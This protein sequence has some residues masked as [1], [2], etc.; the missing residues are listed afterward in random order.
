VKLSLR[1]AARIAWRET[2][3]SMT[4]FAFVVVAVALGVGALA[5][6]RGFS[7]SVR[8]MLASQTR[9]ILAADLTARQFT[10]PNAE[11]ARKL[12]ALAA[13]GIDRTVI[14]ET[15]SMASSEAPDAVPVLVSLKA[16]DPAKYPYY[17][18]VKLAP[19]MPLAEALRPDT[20][21]AGEDVLIRLGVQVGDWVKLGNQQ[22]RVVA[23]VLSEPDRMSGSL[24][25][26]L[27]VML[28]RAA[29]ERTGLMQFGSRA[30]QRFLFKLGPGSPDVAQAR[31]LLREALP[32]ALVADSTEAHPLIRRGVDRATVFLSLVSLIALIVGA[33]GVAMAMYAHLQQKLDNIAVM[34]SL[35]ATSREIIRIFTLQTLML[36][37]LG[38][39]GGV[40]VGRVI[41]EVF[42]ALVSQIFEIQAPTGWHL[43][44]ALQ[45]VAVGT[46]TTLL[47]TLPPLLAIR[48]V[49]PALILR[50]GMPEA[51]LPLRQRLAES[52]DALAAGLVLLAG[53]AGIAAWLAGSVR[54]GGYFAL[55]LTASLAAL[56]AVAWGLLRLLRGWLRRPPVRLG[57]VTR[58]GLAN[59]HRQGS[60]AQAILVAMSLGVMFTLSVYLIQNSLIDDIVSSAPPGVPNVFLMGATPE[61]VE[62]LK[63]LLARQPGVEGP[64]ELGPSISAQLVKINGRTDWAVE[65]TPAQR[66]A[67]PRTV[68][69][70]DTLP[71]SF[72]ILEGVW[73]RPGG[74]ELAVA[75]QESAAR[76]LNVRPGAQLEFQI[77]NRAVAVRVAAIY[78]QT[79][80][81]AAPDADFVFSRAALAGFPVIYTGGVRV[82]PAQAG[83]IQRAVF[84][85]FPTVT[86]VN[87]ADVLEIVQQVIDQIT[88]V[89]QFLSALAILAGAIIL[90]ASVA[91]TRFRR[92]REVVILKA[93]G[94]T[95][96]HIGRI[97]SIEFLTLGA[98]AGLMG[99][100]LATGFTNLVLTRMLETEFRFH[101]TASLAAIGLT[102]LLAN[103]AGWLASFR[104]LGQKPLEVLR[105][106]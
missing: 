17:G 65:D 24:N 69:W 52:P 92:V 5:G 105:E 20:V 7:Q 38:G 103:V 79:A 45:G 37:L 2:R 56:G 93:L 67:R 85:Q 61:Q 3:S 54:V 48:K 70:E 98:V 31:T 71:R 72:E 40:L 84:Q 33:I 44:A 30:A 19:E 6:V 91:G 34:K 13:Q 41:E 95:R 27:R 1:T 36:G 12:D 14:T 4:K 18:A 42:P 101:W 55:G 39:A 58:Q 94:A 15:V 50:R 63:A 90:A 83:A 73:W 26:G 86:V 28:S 88:L 75:V 62:P 47:F 21:A 97:F 32:N 80:F 57:S 99:A 68:S 100:L 104:I 76:T 66:Y 89:I 46:L 77:A 23:I 53:L 51:R 96:R 82:Q 35:G 11:E 22:F 9:S 29:L 49:R 8:S 102:A 74:N 10:P 25:V 59:L 60:Q 87:I 106:E 81:R 43:D 64:A 78:R 16:V